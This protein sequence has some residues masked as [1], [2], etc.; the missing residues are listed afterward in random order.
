MLKHFFIFIE[1]NFFFLNFRAT[2]SNNNSSSNNGNF[3]FGN[4]VS[5]P[6]NDQ[7][8]DF[9]DFTSAFGGAN[10]SCDNN[11]NKT[12]QNLFGT[13]IP[14]PPSPKEATAGEDFDLFGGSGT[15]TSN[16]N[17]AQSSDLGDLL[18]GLG[19]GSGGSLTSMPN[20]MSAPPVGNTQPSA[21]LFGGPTSLIGMP[22]TIPN[23]S[24]PP[25]QPT[26]N[27]SPFPH[28]P[29][30]S[31]LID[32]PVLAPTQPGTQNLMSGA[33]TNPTANEQQPEKK[34][35][36]LPSTWNDVKGLNMDLANFSLSNTTQKKAAM[37]MNAMKM[38]QS[39]SKSPS[40]L[41]PMGKGGF[42]A[43]AAPALKPQ[44]PSGGAFD[45]L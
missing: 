20:L 31:A 35:S 12:D 21:A 26:S 19:G 39:S 11:T 44:P 18:G 29:N 37:S 34:A 23:S 3:G 36:N 22:S 9:A 17:P 27:I 2:A 14:A 13:G 16:A 24:L 1:I 7:D 15:V 4:S 41:S 25:L 32:S 30:P 5:S 8:G 28:Q 45:L 40:P 43:P 6:N 38:S 10:S 42:P 33:T